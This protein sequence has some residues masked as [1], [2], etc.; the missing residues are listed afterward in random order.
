MYSIQII[1]KIFILFRCCHIKLFSR[2]DFT[3]AESS[4]CRVASTTTLTGVCIHDTNNL[5][6]NYVEHNETVI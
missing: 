1:K 2:L 6:I 3:Q 4:P 5:R